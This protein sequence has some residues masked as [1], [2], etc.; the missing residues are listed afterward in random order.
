MENIS[1]WPFIFFLTNISVF[2]LGSSL[3]ALLRIQMIKE[4][5]KV[6]RSSTNDS[7]LYLLKCGR[8]LPGE[9]T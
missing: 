5:K 2:L 1:P 3:L 6:P 9:K 8:N 7:S 4:G